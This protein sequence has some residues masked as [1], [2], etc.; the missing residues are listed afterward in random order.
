MHILFIYSSYQPGLSLL[1][2]NICELALFIWC[3]G[4]Y[5]YWGTDSKTTVGLEADG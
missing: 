3:T 1:P 2:L 5:L 4:C